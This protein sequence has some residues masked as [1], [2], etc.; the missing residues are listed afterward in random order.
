M[1]MNSRAY[2]LAVAYHQPAGVLNGSRVF[3]DFIELA[4]SRIQERNVMH[5]SRSDGSAV[6]EV[7]AHALAKEAHSLAE[8]VNLLV[9]HEWAIP[10]PPPLHAG[11]ALNLE[12]LTPRQRQIAELLIQTGDS[13]KEIAHKL[14]ISEGTMR[15]HVEQ[16]YRIVKVHKRAELSTRT[17]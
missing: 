6:L 16:I 5:L 3:L 15:K 11:A 4:R 17:R 9:M 10:P 1:E 7:R 13:Y 8:D 2:E 14:G 12:K